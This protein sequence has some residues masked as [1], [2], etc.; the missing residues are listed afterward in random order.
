M[1]AKPYLGSGSSM[2]W[3]PT[4]VAEARRADLGPA[5][6]DAPE[7]VE[8]QHSR[9]EGDDVERGQ[10]PR[11]H[12]VDIG[13]GVRRGDA[14]EVVRVVD[15]GR[16]EVH[17]LHESDL[18]VQAVDGGVVERVGAHEKRRVV[19]G[20]SMGDDLPQVLGAEFARSA[21]AVRQR[22]QPRD[23]FHR[24]SPPSVPSRRCRRTPHGCR[25]TRVAICSRTAP[26]TRG[27]RLS[28]RH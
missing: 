26:G 16:E 20:G 10:R 22:G 13:E 6:Q 27:P 19:Y 7:V 1:T 14:P 21:G 23:L 18:V 4:M 2:V 11:A 24:S 8:R 28:S 3:P 12:R 17:R 9:R 15:H 5:Q 25:R